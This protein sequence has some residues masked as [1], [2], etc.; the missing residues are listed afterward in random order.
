MKEVIMPIE[1]L[2][3]GMWCMDA[4]CVKFW[5]QVF[6]VLTGDFAPPQWNVHLARLRQ[7]ETKQVF[8]PKDRFNGS[9]K[10]VKQVPVFELIALLWGDGWPNS[11]LVV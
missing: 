8:V 7:T 6:K 4:P 11:E 3:P 9:P 1:E 2:P 10:D 5:K